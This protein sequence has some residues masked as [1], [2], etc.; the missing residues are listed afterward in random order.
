MHSLY[1]TT[2]IFQVTMHLANTVGWRYRALSSPLLGRAACNS[3]AAMWLF[4]KMGKANFEKIGVEFS[5][6]SWTSSFPILTSAIRTLHSVYKRL[7]LRAVCI[8]SALVYYGELCPL[9]ACRC[10][11]VCHSTYIQYM[12]CIDNGYTD[13]LSF[14]AQSKCLPCLL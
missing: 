1:M 10:D 8:L 7:V 6:K 11:G 13:G 12:A 3:C 5:E 14:S 9:G 2:G 4:V